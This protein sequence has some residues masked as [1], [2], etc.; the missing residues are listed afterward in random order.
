MNEKEKKMIEEMEQI[1]DSTFSYA[2][3]C[4]PYRY[5]VDEREVSAKEMAT[6]LYNAGCRRI[7]DDE[8]VIK[9]SEY[10]DLQIGKD[11]D[12]GCREG[13][14]V[15]EAYYENI[16]LPK[17][18]QETARDMLF[19][20]YTYLKGAMIQQTTAL[21]IVKALAEHYGIEFGEAEK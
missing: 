14:K 21:M 10:E 15:M 9:K 3:E 12:W 5:G 8:I 18:R 13:Q 4:T 11:Y 7:A 20:I 6:E 16:E 2:M 17:S 19:T 1:L